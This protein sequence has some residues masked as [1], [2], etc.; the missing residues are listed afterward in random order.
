MIRLIA[1]IL[2]VAAAAAG[3]HWLADRPGT[4]VV[5]WQGYVAE[6]SVF[7]AFVMLLLAIGAVMLIWSALRWLWSSPAALGRFFD[8]RRQ[9]RGLDA[10]SSGMIA[11]GAGDRALATR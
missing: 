3:L 7:G 6:T 10:L 1:F 8:R 9:Q 4:I 11:I 2:V 5:D